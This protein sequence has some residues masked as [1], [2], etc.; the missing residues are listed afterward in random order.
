M[1]DNA[2]LRDQSQARAPEWARGSAVLMQCP[3][4]GSN[5]L[6]IEEGGASCA[7]CQKS[8]P[9]KG[10]VPLLCREQHDTYQ[11]DELSVSAANQL[12][13]EAPV[14]GWRAALGTALE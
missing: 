9:V 8:W 2:I 1:P 3:E 5:S 4:C 14:R 7:A 6:Q 11:A 10:G 12:V 13:A